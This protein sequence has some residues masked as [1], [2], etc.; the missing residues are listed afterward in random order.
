MW[1]SKYQ[2]TTIGAKGYGSISTLHPEPNP[3]MASLSYKDTYLH[4]TLTNSGIGGDDGLVISTSSFW[5]PIFFPRVV[6]L[7]LK[8]FND[9]RLRGNFYSS[10]CLIVQPGR[11]WGPKNG[12][13]VWEIQVKYDF[14]ETYTVF[15]CF[16]LA[17]P[18]SSQWIYSFFIAVFLFQWTYH[19]STQQ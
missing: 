2:Q 10:F 14:A 4:L 5:F 13:R 18:D 15:D 11:I 3:K 1:A 12:W 9:S 7:L 19:K 16:F 8:R 17:S 6:F